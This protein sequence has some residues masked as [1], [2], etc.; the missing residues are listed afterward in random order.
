[1]RKFLSI[2]VVG[3]FVLSAFG[4]VALT[5]TNNTPIIKEKII[6]SNPKITDKTDYIQVDLDETSSY[7]MKNN[8]PMLPTYTK[9]YVFDAGTEIS[10][11]SVTFSDKKEMSIEKPIIP[12][13]EKKM[14]STIYKSEKSENNV[15][16]YSEIDVYPEQ[17]YTY[18]IGTGLKNGKPSTYF[19]INANPMIYYPNEN[20]IEY[21]KNVEIQ[22]SYK[23]PKIISYPDTYDLLI[24]T[25]SEFSSSLQDLVD[26][27]NDNNIKT[28]MT[29]LDN[30]PDVGVDI[31]E[32]IKYYIK[33]AI[34]NWGITYVLLVGGGL[35]GE[36]KFPVRYAWV[37]SGNYEK[38]FPSDLYYA[39]IYDS[40]MQFTNWDKDG[41]GKYAEFSSTG[42]DVDIIDFYPDVYLSRIPCITSSDVRTYVEKSIKYS[43]H[44][45]MT[46]KIVQVGGD[47]FPGDSQGINEGEFA[48]EEVLTKL[49]G[50]QSTQ[51][52][53]S[54][55]NGAEKLTKKN[56][57]DA[58]NS[59]VDF[60]DFSG[61]GSYGS[62]A[63]HATNDD[64]VW[65]PDQ[66]LISPYTGWLYIDYG[67][68]NVNIDWKYAVVM[69]NACSCSKFT[70]SEKCMG[71]TAI[72]AKNGG[73]ASFGAAGIGYGSYGTYET[74][75]VMGWMEVHIF[76]SLYDNKILGEV[77]GETLSGYISNFIYSEEVDGSDYKT[78]LE[79]T[80]FGDP[81]LTIDD[82]KD[83]KSINLD[84]TDS[85]YPILERLIDMFPRLER[86]FTYL[87][88]FI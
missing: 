66:T 75:R 34:E 81:S 18:N 64:K 65:L 5:N 51:I 13:P 1:M 3:F 35:E 47:T 16:T 76:E 59:G 24:L 27:K 61:H 38:K 54:Q 42:N 45:K 43:E 15:Q 36:E 39:D 9:Q 80:M 60:V 52:W 33:D 28:I 77:L 70:D 26:Y 31:Q 17:M 73:I 58:I 88:Q 40:E 62:W 29:T 21:Y 4:A 82:G 44:N 67:I 57:A 79:F 46:R 30:I 50:Y 78:V 7:I 74:S 55:K 63:T 37:P 22:Y 8:K 19:T 84:K 10:D 72:N 83:P 53:A 11:I 6:F 87:K 48:N 20:K 41:D 14:I 69:F 56:I 32:S 86:M 2:V 12:T 23:I 25:P 49:P 71:W 85:Q 68:Y